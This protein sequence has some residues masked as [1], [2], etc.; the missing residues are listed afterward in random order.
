MGPVGP[1]VSGPHADELAADVD[2]TA[3]KALD[4]LDQ[5]FGVS[6]QRT[7]VEGLQQIGQ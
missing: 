7:K 6:S 4:G 5:F 3:D 2:I 1:A